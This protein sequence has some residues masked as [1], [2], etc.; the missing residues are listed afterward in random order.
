MADDRP[1]AINCYFLRLGL[2]EDVCRAVA[3]PGFFD[4]FDVSKD[5]TLDHPTYRWAAAQQP[6]APTTTTTL[7]KLAATWAARQRGRAAQLYQ[8]KRLLA[9]F[10]RVLLAPLRSMQEDLAKAPLTPPPPHTYTHCPH[11]LGPLHFMTGKLDWVL[12]KGLTAR[13]WRM[14]NMDFSGSDHRWLVVDAE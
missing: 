11:R 7:G 4:P 5:I 14:G 12:L 8:P 13:A 1:G 9:R 10:P 3:N 2:P 6:P